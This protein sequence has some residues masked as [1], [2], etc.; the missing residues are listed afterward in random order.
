MRYLPRDARV[1]ARPGCSARER[2]KITVT[3]RR[4][5]RQ[6]FDSPTALLL[7]SAPVQTGK[8]FVLFFS[9]FLA[10][11]YPRAADYPAAKHGG[12]YMHNYYIPPAPSSTPWAPEWSADGKS[13]IV[14]MQGSL[15]KVDPATGEAAELAYS[16]KYHSS[17]TCSPDGKWIVYTADDDGRSI[18]LEI[19]NVATGETRALTAGGDIYL[20]PAFSPDGSKLAYV[21]TRP[22]GYF[23]IY[24]RAIRNGEW[25]GEEIALTRDHR[26]PR[27]RLYFGEW[28]MH[29]QPAWTP[30]GRQIVFLSNRGVPL[31]SGHLWRMPAE[32]GGIDQAR[33]ILLEQSLYRA[34][35]AVSPDGR[36]IIYSSSAGAADVH[37]H[38]YVIP[39]EGGAPYKM[40]FGE[41]DDF[42]PR[43][44]P[45][46]E[47]IAY[48]ANEGGLPQLWMLE[49][50]GGKKTKI[51]VQ[52]RRWK[53]PMGRLE[54]RVV[55]QKGA[56]AAAR[57]HVTA[58]D[59]K[60]YPPSGAYARVSSTGRHTFHT[61]GAFTLELPPGK[62]RIEAVKGFEFTPAAAETEVAPGK[63]ARV[64]L[65]LSRLVNMSTRGWRSGSTH[66]HMNYGG[67]LRNTLENLQM[68]SRAEDQNVLNVLIANKDNRI[69]D[70]QYFAP[71]GGAHPV[72]AKDPGLQVIV[73]E[74]YRPPFYG[75][76]FFIGLK[77]RLISP[78]TTGY[79]GTG[80]E[81]LYPSNTDM[82]R[83][84]RAQGALVGYVH[85]FGSEADPLEGSLGGAK[86]FPVDLALGVIDGLEWSQPSRA[87][88]RVWHHAWNNDLPVAPV[89]G[90]D[91][92][93]NLH[94]GKLTGS[95]RTYGW[96]GETFT[97]E[98]WM[99]SVRKGRV[100]FSTGPLVEFRLN[101]LLP[102][103]TLR[104]PRAGT[105][106]VAG[107]VTSIAPLEKVELYRNGRVIRKFPASGGFEAEIPVEESGWYSL[108]A[109]GPAH[110]HLDAEYAQAATN[111]IRV[112]VGEAKIRNRESA[113]YFIRWIDKLQAM[114]GEWLWWR[115]EAE[116]KHVFAQFGQARA[117][118]EQKAREAR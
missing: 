115:S 108:Y 42:H 18:Q 70:W 49:T 7:H 43:W 64:T 84:A 37:A 111:A 93:T 46:G 72:T 109:E 55:E 57:I 89:G 59:G 44:S 112:Y 99:E 81:S 24:V 12:N 78:F 29:L 79:E 16:R 19:L 86:G 95:C 65:T 47:R 80:I 52:A 88:L 104:L 28:D 107:S 60:F 62:T 41:H 39:L 66:V 30:D 22:N 71:G 90:E 67:N 103:E 53:R 31:G 1:V 94:R 76:T 68:V 56:L 36:R 105:V 2:P 40:T 50:Y 8:R 75:H 92:I 117:V 34:R 100:F 85:A 61:P 82:F 74:E 63:T 110:P 51:A 14:A 83:K 10:P 54:V 77:E 21:S 58:A 69:L 96:T 101:D 35:A 113:G 38:L 25:S 116:K 27:D 23:N 32:A 87:Q 33:P 13:L 48:I 3:A 98:S 91:S 5:V 9:L 11:A 102:G 45:D 118:Y 6:V 4:A 17:P 114:A 26:Y 15:W 20:D 106:R 97:A 73:G